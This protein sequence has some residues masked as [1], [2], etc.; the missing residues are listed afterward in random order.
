[1]SE[2]DIL[3]KMA[4]SHRPLVAMNSC[5]KRQTPESPF[6]HFEGTEEE[7]IKMVSLDVAVG[8][9]TQ[10]YREGVILVPMDD[11]SRF[12]TGMVE[13][14]EG[15]ILVGKFEAR[16]EG[17]AP[18]RAIR[19][20]RE[21]Q[22]KQPAK[23]VEIVLYRHDVLAEKDENETDAAWEIVS[24]NGYPTEVP[25]PISPITLMHNHFGSDGGTDTNMSPEKFEAALR[26]SF[27]YHKNIALLEGA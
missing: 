7:L 21:G 22:G 12:F 23:C 25:A 13:L 11:P 3:K 2:A 26:E 17:E 27:T 24:L 5:A 8:N 4:E 6:T 10:G 19:V 9:S 18:R 20:R 14:R 16:Q 15:D 1:M